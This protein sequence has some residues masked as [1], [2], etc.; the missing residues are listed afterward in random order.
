ME[1]FLNKFTD[2]LEKEQ[3]KQVD[4]AFD[5]AWKQTQIEHLKDRNVSLDAKKNIFV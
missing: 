5:I 3:S 4:N 1:Q 2:R